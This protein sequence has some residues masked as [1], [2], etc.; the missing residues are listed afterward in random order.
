MGGSFTLSCSYMCSIYNACI[1]DLTCSTHI[2]C[3]IVEARK[4]AKELLHIFSSTVCSSILPSASPQYLQVNEL[5][6]YIFNSSSNNTALPDSATSELW[7]ALLT[8][9]ALI[10]SL[11]GKRDTSVTSFAP[12]ASRDKW[13]PP[14]YT[15]LLEILPH[16]GSG[17]IHI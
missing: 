14:R 10:S 17:D 11:L 15:S 16:G 1:T 4:I 5:S 13:H 7:H 6:M 2:F 9:M 8:N 3:S 12:K